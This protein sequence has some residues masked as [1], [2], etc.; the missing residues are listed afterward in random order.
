M[1]LRS[2]ARSARLRSASSTSS[3]ESLCISSHDGCFHDVAGG[4][5]AAA[6]AASSTGASS[7][8]AKSGCAHSRAIRAARVAAGP[9]P[10]FPSLSQYSDNTLT[11]KKRA[12]IISEL[13]LLTAITCASLS[14]SVLSLRPVASLP[15]IA[16]MMDSLPLQKEDRPRRTLAGSA[17]GCE[18]ARRGRLDDIVFFGNYFT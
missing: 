3:S 9:L 18:A 6:A 8:S 4:L 13:R 12:S 11:S 5:T 2:S 1:A 10:D 14:T 15:S 16:V 7:S 17:A